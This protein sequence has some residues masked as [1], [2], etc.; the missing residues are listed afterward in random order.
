MTHAERLVWLT[1]LT[2]EAYVIA[3]EEQGI[4]PVARLRELPAQ[5]GYAWH[6]AVADLVGRLEWPLCRYET[7]DE[8]CIPDHARRS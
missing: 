5:V 6:A 2:Y 7:V 8:A 3:L 4:A 1:T